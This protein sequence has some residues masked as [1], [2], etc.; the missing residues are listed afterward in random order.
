MDMREVFKLQTQQTVQNDKGDTSVDWI[1]V[2]QG[3]ARVANLGSREFWEASA[4]SAENTLKFFTRYHPSFD[5]L[6][7]RSV[8]LM[9]RGKALDVTAIDNVNYQNEQII[10]RAVVKNE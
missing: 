3:Y 7:T 9:W 10:I 6:D 8:R 1:D 4:V 5:S 2:Y